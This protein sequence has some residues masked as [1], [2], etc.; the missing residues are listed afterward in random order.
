MKKIIKNMYAIAVPFIAHY[1]GLSLAPYFCPAGHLTI[2][3]GE[4]I[5]LNKY[6]GFILG[7]DLKNVC[8]GI[9]QEN[10]NNLNKTN[11]ILNNKYS[12]LIT[13]KEAEHD[14]MQNI[15]LRWLIIAHVLPLGLN[16]YQCAAIASFVYNLGT[17]TFFQ[18]TLLRKI[19]N[20]PQDISIRDE[21]HKF[22]YANGKPLSGLVKRRQA[23][24]NL[25]FTN[26]KPQ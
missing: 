26:V 22:I 24:A 2:G 23:E 4:V 5:K 17:H 11:S 9:L 15:K 18:S 16:D 10:N 7:K 12:A 21:F 14:L 3:Y 20:N 19:R 25:Y 1:E 6:Y 8:S 13:Q